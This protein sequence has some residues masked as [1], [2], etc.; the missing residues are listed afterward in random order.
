MSQAWQLAKTS[1][2]RTGGTV[3]SPLHARAAAASSTPWIFNWDLHH[4]VDV[5]DDFHAELRAMRETVAMGDM[6]P[7]CKATISGPDAA[8][9]VDMLT[10]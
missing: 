7:M 8:R 6:S 1:R 3:G 4:V 10:C 9:F 5:Y 2:F